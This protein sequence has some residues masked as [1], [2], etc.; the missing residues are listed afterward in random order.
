VNVPG[1]GTRTIIR[2]GI[3]IIALVSCLAY[4]YYAHAYGLPQGSL[5][6]LY[7][8]FAIALA[9]VYLLGRFVRSS[10]LAIVVICAMIIFFYLF[11][12]RK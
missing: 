7:V 8:G 12:A 4:Y 2:E 6:I 5:F 3:S 10:W 11:G 9:A 1:T